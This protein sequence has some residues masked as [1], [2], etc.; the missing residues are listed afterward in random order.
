M[1]LVACKESAERDRSE[2]TSEKEVI[3]GSMLCI[4]EPP[5]TGKDGRREIA[6]ICKE[7]EIL[8]HCKDAEDGGRQ[9]DHCALIK[10]LV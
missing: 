4:L 10:E 6:I 2:C 3:G 8:Q 9:D 7:L 5:D 1:S